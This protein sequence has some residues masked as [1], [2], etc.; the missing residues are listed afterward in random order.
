MPYICTDRGSQAPTERVNGL[1]MPSARF[2][3]IGMDVVLFGGFR[4]HMPKNLTGDTNMLRVFDRR[5][6][7]GDIAEK[8]RVYWLAECPLRYLADACADTARGHRPPSDCD[9]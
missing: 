8:V 4:I 3:L 1:A 5:R 9:P 7:C 2:D 6:C